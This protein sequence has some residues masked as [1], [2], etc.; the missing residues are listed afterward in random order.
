VEEE[1]GAI[2]EFEPR[3]WHSSATAGNPEDQIYPIILE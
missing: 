3:L 2:R 1:L